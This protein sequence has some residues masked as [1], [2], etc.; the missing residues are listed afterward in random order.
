[1]FRAQ[2]LEA[3]WILS[4]LAYADSHQQYYIFQYTLPGT[5]VSFVEVIDNILNFQDEF[6]LQMLDQLYHFFGNVTATNDEVCQKVRKTF[7]LVRCMNTILQ[8]V[9]TTNFPLHLA[10]N[11]IWVAR[12]LCWSCARILT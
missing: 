3:A 4:N 9:G 5:N 8:R 6:D 12:N 11:I 2:G 7:D 10:S 1:M